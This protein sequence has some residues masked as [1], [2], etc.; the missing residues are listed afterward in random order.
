[1]FDASGLELINSG[2]GLQNKL[3]VPYPD[4]RSTEDDLVLKL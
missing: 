2:K 3:H 1:L 4:A